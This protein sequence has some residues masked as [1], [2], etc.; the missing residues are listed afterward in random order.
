MFL[1]GKTCSACNSRNPNKSTF[2]QYCGNPLQTDTPSAA[3]PEKAPEK[4]PEQ[5]PASASKKVVNAAFVA[6]F[7]RSIVLLFLAAESS[8]DSLTKTF[9]FGILV[10]AVICIMMAGC[11]RTGDRKPLAILLLGCAILE[12]IRFCSTS[13]LVRLTY[14]WDQLP[15]KWKWSFFWSVLKYLSLLVLGATAVGRSFARKQSIRSLIAR[16]WLIPIVIFGVLALKDVKNE[17]KV[18]ALLVP[19]VSKQFGQ[20]MLSLA[21]ILD[22]LACLCAYACLTN[23]FAKNTALVSSEKGLGYCLTDTPYPADLMIWGC[24]VRSVSVILPYLGRFG[25]AFL[26]SSNDDL[27]SSMSNIQVYLRQLIQAMT[28]RAMALLGLEGLR[29]DLLLVIPGMLMIFGLWMFALSLKRSH[30]SPELFGTGI[31]IVRFLQF[32]PAIVSSILLL[33]AGGAALR[34]GTVLD[35]KGTLAVG[36]LIFFS[37]FGRFLVTVYVANFAGDLIRGAKRARFPKVPLFIS[38]G[39]LLTGFS[40]LLSRTSGSTTVL[41]GISTI[42]FAIGMFIYNS[43]LDEFEFTSSMEQPEETSV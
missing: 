14:V 41:R 36:W 35:M 6:L 1:M 27:F 22:G 16:Y 43:R 2:C 5:V 7:I 29:A 33:A 8:T 4:V 42:L 40:D 28:D 17:M 15:S 23:I 34:L 31:K 24:I 26:S 25:S 12:I 30:F 13:N 39:T 9:T 32:P 20:L 10:M 37:A 21:R 38:L 3:A 11:V 18:F 19:H